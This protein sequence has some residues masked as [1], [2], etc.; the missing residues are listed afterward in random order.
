MH[1]FGGAGDW[2]N[3]RFLQRYGAEVGLRSGRSFNDPHHWQLSEPRGNYPTTDRSMAGRIHGQYPDLDDERRTGR[4]MPAPGPQPPSPPSS[5]APSADQP[6]PQQP[7]AERRAERTPADQ[8]R[9]DEPPAPPRTPGAAAPPALENLHSQR[10]RFADELRDSATHERLL[11]LTQAENPQNPQAFMESVMNRAAARQQTLTE[12]MN[13]RHYYPR[14][15]LVGRTPQ[16]RATMEAALNRVLGGS[17]MIHYATGNASLNVGFGY[18]HGARDPFTYRDPVT[19]ERYGIEN[20]ES[21]IRW[22]AHQ[23]DQEQ[24]AGQASARART[25][26]VDIG[27]VTEV[28]RQPPPSLGPSGGFRPSTVN[29]DNNI[30][31]DLNRAIDQIS[32]ENK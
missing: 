14:V 1:Q 4:H 30:D 24:L 20:R 27:P 26:H 2:V 5:Q 23:N 28:S 32:K 6:S 19:H 12:A 31:N 29:I 16:D 13:D 9:V 10:T 21:D 7:I 11:R 17:N 15:S 25:P 3:D 18:G 8:P 22:A